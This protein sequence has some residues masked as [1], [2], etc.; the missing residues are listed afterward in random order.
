MEIIILILCLISA[1]AGIT[2]AVVLFGIKK[3]ID[4]KDNETATKQD[5]SDICEELIRQFDQ[6]RSTIALADDSLKADVSRELY[7]VKADVRDNNVSF[8][9]EMK[10]ELGTFRAEIKGELGI[11]KGEVKSEVSGLKDDTRKEITGLKSEIREEIVNLKTENKTEIGSLKAENKADTGSLKTEVKD[12]MTNVATLLQTSQQAGQEAVNR[13]IDAKLTVIEDNLKKVEETLEMRLT[14]IQM[15]IT[16]N[17]KTIRD[18]NSKKL[19]EIRG[20]VDEKLSETLNKRINES[21]KTVSDQL[22]QVY[23]SI[24]EMQTLA[25][26]VGSLKQVLSGVKTR[27]ILGEIQLSSILSEILTQEQYE[28]NINTIPGSSERVEFAIKLPGS[29]G[30]HVYLPIDSK[31]PGDRYQAVLDAR[32]LGD[33]AA[34]ETARKQLEAVLKSEAKDI[35]NKYVEPPYTTAFGIMF[36]PFEGLYAEVVN[37]GMVEVLQR[38][39]NVNIAGPSTMAA[40][41]NSLQMGFKTL[42]IQKRSD[43]VWKV[44]GEVKGEFGKFET[45]LDKM[46]SH[47]DQTSRDLEM[48]R[49]TRSNAIIRKLRNVESID[50]NDAGE[51]QAI[52]ETED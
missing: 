22:E 7:N 31:F 25:N 32:E 33:K 19:D 37:M 35:K 27:G 20:T 40:M 15:S 47:L 4:I 24:G 14:G 46:H 41:L 13:L 34:C 11:F 38:D 29:D 49:S 3:R 42:A 23:K 18:E 1:I 51:P 30:G 21:F 5:L 36:L 48:L 50:V 10:E 44:L 39:Y 43:E 52:E 9:A 2:G 28:E 45:V 8:R 26:D 17:L 6:L 12:S 16:D